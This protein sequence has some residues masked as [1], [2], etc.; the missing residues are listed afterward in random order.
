MGFRQDYLL[1]IL[2]T[3]PLGCASTRP[4]AADPGV[5]NVTV[6][7]KVGVIDLRDGDETVYSQ[8]LMP[9]DLIVNTM[10]LGRAAKK[11]EW[12]FAVLPH[13]HSMIVLDPSDRQTGILECRFRGARRV[14]IEEL[15]LYSYNTV[16]RLRDARRLDLDRLRQFADHACARCPKYSFKSWLAF[17]DNLRPENGDQVSR[18]YTCS[19][20]VAAAYHYAGMTLDV[21]HAERRVIT[22]LSL[23]VSP[24][25]FNGFS[26][27]D[28]VTVAQPTEDPPI[29]RR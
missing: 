11:R 28:I 7:D 4:T 25:R 22:P 21:A 20:L 6:F 5:P 3:L 16:Y 15:K 14:G 1:A 8:L 12:L 26:R 29:Q 10:R 18:Q 9:G 13:G 24:G 23:A 2:A 19:T 17:N 27:P